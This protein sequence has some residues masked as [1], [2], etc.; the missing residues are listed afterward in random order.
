M[1]T[2]LGAIKVWNLATKNI[3]KDVRKKVSD[4]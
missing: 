3:I 1:A 4:E 2:I